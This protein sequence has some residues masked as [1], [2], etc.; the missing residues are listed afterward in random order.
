MR[1]VPPCG[2]FELLQLASTNRQRA[3]PRKLG[4]FNVF[5]DRF[6]IRILLTWI[7]CPSYMSE[8]ESLTINCED[9]MKKCSSGQLEICRGDFHAENTACAKFAVHGNAAAHC[10]AKMFDDCESQAGPPQLARTG[11]IDPVKPLE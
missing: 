8:K 4:A 6:T 11:L 2:V 1:M 7:S 9:N 3:N 10:L 5:I